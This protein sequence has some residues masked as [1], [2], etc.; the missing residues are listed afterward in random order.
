MRPPGHLCGWHP[1][2]HRQPQGG[3]EPSLAARWC[4]LGIV[5]AAS[6]RCPCA[7]AGTGHSWPA[8]A[9]RLLRLTRPPLPRPSTPINPPFDPPQELTARHGDFYAF[10]ISTPPDQEA[11]ADALVRGLAPGARCT[12]ALA[13]TRKY[14]L[15]VGEVTLPGECRWPAGCGWGR[16][17]AGCER[18]RTDSTRPQVPQ[19]PASSHPPTHPPTP[20]SR[21]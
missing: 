17:W 2:V 21:V 3:R 12:Y 15:P 6:G 8:P 10:T 19:G 13:G 9:P 14:E 16:R 11:E 5:G 18:T 7:P 4:W 1:G 20:R